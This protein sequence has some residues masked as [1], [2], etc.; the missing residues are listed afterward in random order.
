[1]VW[2]TSGERGPLFFFLSLSLS[3]KKLKQKKIDFA[4]P[5]L[6][7]YI[8]PSLPA[9]LEAK[10]SNQ[11]LAD[12]PPPTVTLG[13]EESG[14]VVERC[15]VRCI[16]FSQRGNCLRTFYFVQFFLTIT[17]HWKSTRKLIFPPKR[18]VLKTKWAKQKT[19]LPS[20]SY[21]FLDWLQVLQPMAGFWTRM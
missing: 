15:S 20:N 10:D 13:T 4:C 18:I 11:A 6:F 7:S 12:D 16:R 8:L 19:M 2:G 17:R 1:M 3:K 21:C 14:C 9:L 5:I